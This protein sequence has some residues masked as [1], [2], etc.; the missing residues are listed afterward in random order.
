MIKQ[1]GKYGINFQYIIIVVHL[2]ICYK[3]IPLNGVSND[4]GGRNCYT[5]SDNL[6][7][8]YICDLH[9]Q[10]MIAFVILRNKKNRYW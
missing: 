5:Y 6:K 7:G 10:E 3:L 4:Y 8:A 9:I 1:E 2:S